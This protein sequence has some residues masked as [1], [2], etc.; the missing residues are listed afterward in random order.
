MLQDNK[1]QSLHA[2]GQ[3]HIALD[4]E[5]KNDA[6]NV[7]KSMGLTIAEA[8]RIFLREVVREQELPFSV[9]YTAKETPNK[10]TL[11]AMKELDSG[12]GEDTTLSKLKKTWDSI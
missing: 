11:Q 5:L 3:V 9:Y 2:R 6:E 8:V 10:E 12:H 7:L 4:G 1:Q